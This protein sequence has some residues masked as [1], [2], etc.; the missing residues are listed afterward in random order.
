[1]R[2]CFLTGSKNNAGD[3]L[4]KHRA[5][6][7]LRKYRPEIEILD[8]NGWEANKF[9]NELK[10]CETIVLCGGP[11]IQP[12]MWENIYNFDLD[13][14]QNKRLAALGVG[15]KTTSISASEEDAYKFTESSTNLIRNLA[16]ASVRD[17]Q[18]KRIL[19]KLMPEKNIHVTGCPATFEDEKIQSGK[20]IIFSVGV[21]FSKNKQIS[22]QQKEIINMLIKRFG[23]KNLIVAFHH[24]VDQT[25]LESNNADKNLY[26]H[27]RL[28]IEY[29]DHHE[30]AYEDISGNVNKLLS[31]YAS[32]KYHV[33]YRLHAHIN[34]LANNKPTLLIAEDGRGLAF[35]E[36]YDN[37]N[38]VPAFKQQLARTIFQKI[39]MKYFNYDDRDQTI[40]SNEVINRSLDSLESLIVKRSHL[41]KSMHHFI[42]SVL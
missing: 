11:S 12:K 9:E 18:T 20:N 19:S 25:Y 13:I 38:V 22:H 2:Y 21:T 29:L 37:L 1:M 7:L 31:L 30:I 3:F 39:K 10:T 15:A 27:N 41:E 28:L 23:K 42:T 16:C 33:G 6:K 17:I 4:I 5:F 24:G 40:I 35:S 8:I 32:A 34:M 36:L 14:L 26:K